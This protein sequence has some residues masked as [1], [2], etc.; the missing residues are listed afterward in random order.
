MFVI[1]LNDKIIFSTEFIFNLFIN[2]ANEYYYVTSSKIPIQSIPGKSL[3]NFPK[4]LQMQ[5]SLNFEWTKVHFKGNS[6]VLERWDDIRLDATSPFI[7]LKKLKWNIM[8]N[9]KH[10]LACGWYL[11]LNGPRK[12]GPFCIS[13][14]QQKWDKNKSDYLNENYLYI[15]SA[16]SII[17]S[18]RSHS[19]CLLFTFYSTILAK[20]FPFT[21]K[22]KL[23]N[24]LSHSNIISDGQ[25]ELGYQNQFFGN[26]VNSFCSLFLPKILSSHHFRE[27]NVHIIMYEQCTQTEFQLYGAI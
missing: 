20:K 9:S 16:Q 25:F 13:L 23:R 11:I 10:L 27:S 18:S 22:F 4:Y 26:F 15:T 1:D 5:S 21:A 19:V 17:Y 2:I 14:P 8:L 6:F 24:L 12:K 7:L 3:E